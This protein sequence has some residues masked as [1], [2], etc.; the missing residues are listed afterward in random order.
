M[1]NLW[2]SEFLRM[3]NEFCINEYLLLLSRYIGVKGLHLQIKFWY[4]IFIRFC[5]SIST[6]PD[7]DSYASCH[8]DICSSNICPGNI[9][10]YHKYLTCYWTIF[11][12]T[13]I[14]W[15]TIFFELISFLLT[16]RLRSKVI[17]LVLFLF[18]IF[19]WV[20][21]LASWIFVPNFWQKIPSKVVQQSVLP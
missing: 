13:L 11:L 9:C 2:K 8:G 3:G 18:S 20:L 4:L 21:G 16:T 10:T 5:P 17:S 7:I 6:S 14:S 1:E 12:G 19:H 15:I